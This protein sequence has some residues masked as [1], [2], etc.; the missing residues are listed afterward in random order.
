MMINHNC[1]ICGTVFSGGPRAAYCPDCRAEIMRQRD[2]ERKRNGPLRNLGSTDNCA[3]CG[4]QYIVTSGLQKYCPNCAKDAVRAIDRVHGLEYY[5][6]NKERINPARNQKRRK[7]NV[8]VICG[9][10]FLA[11]GSPTVTCSDECH[12]KLKKIWQ[13]RADDKRRPRNKKAD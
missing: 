8:C 4:N 10:E 6:A 1:K 13:K 2:R 12:N 5:H 3:V 7:T 11:N 9:K